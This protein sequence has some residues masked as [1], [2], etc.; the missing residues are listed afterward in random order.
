MSTKN[1]KKC[2]SFLIKGAELY[3]WELF[4]ANIIKL[5]CFYLNAPKGNVS[6]YAALH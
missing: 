4:E 2:T 1:K 6:K 5:L 3:P